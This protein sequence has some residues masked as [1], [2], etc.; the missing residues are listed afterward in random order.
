[1]NV[2][3]ALTIG[4]SDPS[5]AAGVQADLKVFAAFRLYGMSVITALT[6][7]NSSRVSEVMRV[8]DKTVSHQFRA[9]YEDLPI[10]ALKIGML[11]S[12]ENIGMVAQLIEECKLRN[13]V[14][15]PVFLSSSGAHLIEKG[16]A[17]AMVKL[18]FPLVDVVTPN[19]DEASRLSGL[20]IETPGDMKEAARI[21]KDK[22]PAYVFV[23]GGHLEGRAIDILYNGRTFLTLDAPRLTG[24][25]FRGTG[26]A[27][28]ASIAS[29]LAKGMDMKSSA[30]KAKDF[31]ARSIKTGY[32]DLGK[33]MGILN[34]NHSML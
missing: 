6:S 5:G 31:V 29:C 11:A 21:I 27:L 17:E 19:I 7:Q 20:K 28:S 34:H 3:T 4:G 1:M 2:K 22:G 15:D 13:I 10:D 24:K 25:E 12:I 33:G 26:C 16:G 18:L 14:L 9:I 32:E 23:K 8:S 30:E